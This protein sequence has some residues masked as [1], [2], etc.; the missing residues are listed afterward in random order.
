MSVSVHN[1]IYPP[2][3]AGTRPDQAKAAAAIW[4]VIETLICSARKNDCRSICL[5]RTA[6]GSEIVSD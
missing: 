3:A 2:R 1:H 6:L 5:S 4:T